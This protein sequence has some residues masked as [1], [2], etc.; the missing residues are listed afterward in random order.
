M[1]FE[2][3]GRSLGFIKYIFLPFVFLNYLVLFFCGYSIVKG[4]VLKIFNDYLLGAYFLLFL[5]LLRFFPNLLNLFRCRNFYLLFLNLSFTFLDTGT[6]RDFLLLSWLHFDSSQLHFNLFSQQSFV[7]LDD[8][9]FVVDVFVLRSD[10]PSFFEVLES[11]TV[12]SLFHEEK[13]F[14]IPGVEVDRLDERVDDSVLSVPSCAVETELHSNVD[15]GPL[16]ILLFTV[17]ADLNVVG[18]TLLSLM[19]LMLANSLSLV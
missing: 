18:L 4:K 10:D 3:C 6:L 2:V 19:F 11:S 13:L 9:R 8:R 14:S 15:G 16:G 7:L 12:A 17:D 1:G 5:F